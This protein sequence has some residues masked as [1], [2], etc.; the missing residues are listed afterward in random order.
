M[1]GENKWSHMCKLAHQLNQSPGELTLTTTQLPNNHVQT[2]EIFSYPNH[3]D[4]CNHMHLTSSNIEQLEI[5][6]FPF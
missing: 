3:C 6:N 1:T 4:M 2:S 5:N